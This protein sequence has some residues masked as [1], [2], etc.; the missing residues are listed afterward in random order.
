MTDYLEADVFEFDEDDG[1]SAGFTTIQN[2]FFT[3]FMPEAQGNYVKVYLAGLMRC[4]GARSEQWAS[5]S[6]IAEEQKVSEKTV[7]RAWA[8]WEEKGLVRRIPRFIRD[9]SN[10]M[11]YRTQPD[12]EYRIQTSNIIKFRRNLLALV[13]HSF[14]GGHQRPGGV[15]TDDQGGLDTHDQGGWSP[16]TTKERQIEEQ[17]IEEGQD[18]MTMVGLVESYFEIAFDRKPAGA[19]LRSLL[20]LAEEYSIEWLTAAML[21]GALQSNI[22]TIKAPIR[23]IEGVMK[24]WKTEGVR[25]TDIAEHFQRVQAIRR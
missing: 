22:R 18:D 24:N 3:H 9:R 8:Y 23:Y 25:I 12:N 4:F 7:R 14:G 5:V 21:E 6:T 19:E 17:Q 10:P 15:V 20:A 1:S 2:V 16:V 13:E 11:D